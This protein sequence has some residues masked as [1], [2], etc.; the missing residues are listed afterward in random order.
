VREAVEKAIRGAV[1]GRLK[2]M[3]LSDERRAQVLDRLEF[4]GLREYVAD[5][6]VDGEYLA[7]EVEQWA[8]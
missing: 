5:R 3:A 4:K 6:G 1:D 7:S 2:R 8:I